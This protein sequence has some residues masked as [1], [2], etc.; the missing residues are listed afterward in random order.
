MAIEKIAV[1]GDLVLYP[2]K[3]SAVASA[4]AERAG[5]ARSY[6]ETVWCV[7]AVTRVSRD[8]YATGIR[9]YTAA[10]SPLDIKGPINGQYVG[11][12]SKLAPLT[13]DAVARRLAEQDFRSIA[14][15]RD[16]IL[17]VIAEARAE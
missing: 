13:A 14:A 12:A 11:S 17:A 15:A 7:G 5:I 4:S 2:I 8:G 16:A 3:R 6:N 9:S 10:G 1:P